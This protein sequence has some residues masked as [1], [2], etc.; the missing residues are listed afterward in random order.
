MDV[1]VASLILCSLVLAAGAQTPVLSIEPRSATVRQGESV[2][3][4]CR[5]QSGAQPVRLEWKRTNNQP[6]PDN[7]KIGPDG[8]VLTVASSRPGNQGTYRC[9]A[10]N[11][12]GKAHSSASLTVKQSPKIDITPSSPVK[13]RAG[14]P[15]KLECHATGRP[16][17][18]VTWHRQGAGETGQSSSTEAKAVV[19]VSAAR[20]EDAG[21][22]VCKAQNSEGTAETKVEVRVEGG[23]QTATMPQASVLQAEMVAVEG[24]TVT[25]HCQAT[26]SPTPTIT[27]SKL[28]AP[29]PWQHRVSDGTL[30][31]QSLG[32]QDSGQYICN[33]TNAAGASEATV[34]LEVETPP[35]ATSIP[36]QLRVQP[37]DTIRVQCLAHGTPPVTFQWTRVRGVM[38]ARAQTQD[39]V[40][41]ISQAKAADAGTYKCVATNKWGS[42]ETQARVTV[43]SA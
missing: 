8:S 26:G 34:Q 43:R 16:R 1:C 15:I 4:R 23:A 35:Y 12:F 21:V 31:L 13:V 22:Y 5:V 28:R 18:S 33:A 7:V 3:F 14:E 42:S 37:G 19:Q 29:L 25:L 11:A 9:V 40:L 30:T 6:L 39:G 24:S 27:W 36:E 20:S 41:V 32:R 10:T 38:P 2:S 17:P